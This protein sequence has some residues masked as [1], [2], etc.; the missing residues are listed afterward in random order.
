[1]DDDRFPGEALDVVVWRSIPHIGVM[2][3]PLMPLC[4]A[5][6]LLS[7]FVSVTPDKL[8]IF[9]VHQEYIH[10]TLLL[11][12]TATA[13]IQPRSSTESPRRPSSINARRRK[14]RCSPS[15]LF[16][17]RPLFW[18]SQLPVASPSLTPQP[19]L[20]LASPTSEQD[21]KAKSRSSG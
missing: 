12:S 8:S 11:F 18:L 20:S 4:A 1:M 16:W 7:L 19:R 15:D 2:H 17:L 21:H 13:L 3:R 6:T 10:S 14:S 9:P 5:I